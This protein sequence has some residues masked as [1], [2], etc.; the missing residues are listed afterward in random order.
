VLAEGSA[1]RQ[2]LLLG[3]WVPELEIFAETAHDI[4]APRPWSGGRVG[5]VGNL[6]CAAVPLPLDS[7]ISFRSLNG[8]ED[9]TSTS[10]QPKL[11]PIRQRAGNR[12][13][14]STYPIKS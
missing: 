3:P 2:D 11:N 1:G 14:M 10:I 12:I 4:P 6:T 13:H 7:L 9:T 5:E 8:L